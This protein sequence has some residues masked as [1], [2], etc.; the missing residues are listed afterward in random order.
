MHLFNYSCLTCSYP[1]LPFGRSYVAAVSVENVT[2][3]LRTEVSTVMKWVVESSYIYSSPYSL[4]QYIW[5]RYV[6]PK[7][8]KMREGRRTRS[9]ST[10]SSHEGLQIICTISTK[11]SKI[12]KQQ[13]GC[14]APYTMMRQPLFSNKSILGFL[15]C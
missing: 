14:K 6:P 10:V 8:W 12:A 1:L 5:R 15:S 11:V 9:T 2:P 3:I 4:W 7:R 13:N